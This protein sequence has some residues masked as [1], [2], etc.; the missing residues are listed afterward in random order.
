[1]GCLLYYYYYV[2]DFRNIITDTLF[3]LCYNNI[4]RSHCPIWS[5]FANELLIHILFVL[6]KWITILH[7]KYTI[8]GPIVLCTVTQVY[9]VDELFNYHF[10][11]T[12]RNYLN[13]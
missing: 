12:K 6:E 11:F 2:V 9:V 1:M 8:R 7:I 13:D 3:L 5:S 4:K 10:E